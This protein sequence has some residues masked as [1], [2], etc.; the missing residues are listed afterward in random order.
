VRLSLHEDSRAPAEMFDRFFAAESTCARVPA[1]EPV[2][3]DA[4]LWSK[5]TALEA[6]FMRMPHGGEWSKSSNSRD[7]KM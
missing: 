6:F 3:F 1:G 2:G 7:R 5:L 4:D